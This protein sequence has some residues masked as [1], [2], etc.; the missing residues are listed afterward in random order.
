MLLLFFLAEALS[1]EHYHH[2]FHHHH[3]L[4]HQFHDEQLED[5]F[6][7][8]RSIK[9]I[10]KKVTKPVEK[11]VK[12][13]TKPVEKVVKK[14]LET[15]E[16]VVYDKSSSEWAEPIKVTSVEKVT[17]SKQYTA[18]D[19]SSLVATIVSDFSVDKEKLTNFMKKAKLTSTSKTLLNTLNFGAKQDKRYRTADLGVAAVKVTKGSS[20]FTVDVKKAGGNAQVWANTVKKSTKRV[21]VSKSSSKSVSWRPLTSTE[22][23]GVY[24]TIQT[25]I[26]SEI[27]E[28]KKI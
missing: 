19:P 3:H 12:A 15:V 17:E 22:L 23:S 28:V 10:V 7:L 8:G 4:H 26:A 25:T 6:H 14:S 27:A 5:N 1:R 20:G 2:G 24:Q 9:K 16:K 11:A 18:S 13:V 21:L